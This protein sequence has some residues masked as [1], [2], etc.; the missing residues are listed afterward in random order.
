[1]ISSLNLNE[2]RIRLME[3]SLI[4]GATEP[5]EK[6]ILAIHSVNLVNGLICTGV[7]EDDERE[8]FLL[9]P[10]WKVNS[11]GIYSLRYS[12]PK[13][14]D[15]IFMKFIHDR[16]ILDINA[17]LSTNMGQIYSTEL[18]LEKAVSKNEAEGWVINE[19]NLRYIHEKYAKQLLP[20]LLR[21]V[22]EK[23]SLISPI[24]I[25]G[26][27]QGDFFWGR[28]PGNPMGGPLGVGVGGGDLNPFPN[29]PLPFAPIGGLP[30]NMMGP[31]HP[32]FTGGPQPSGFVQPG[33][34]RPGA[35]YDP[36][37]P[38]GRAPNPDLFPR[39][40]FPGPGGPGSLGGPG[41]LG[42][43]GSGLF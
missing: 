37:G 20:K 10:N 18:S 32:F 11:E 12:N 36:I 25:Q 29:N 2:I 1:M 35:R 39:P 23:Q 27:G 26:A 15:T 4:G 42:G 6:V 8:E 7:Q 43:P 14:G 30:G 22:P 28:P 21:K 41:G 19:E 34:G 5:H 13:N 3:I 17:V 31:N 24:H 16:D 33:P 38:M 40:Q 9:P